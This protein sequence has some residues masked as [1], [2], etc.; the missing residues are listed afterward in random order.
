VLSCGGLIQKRLSAGGEVRVVLLF[1]RIYT[2]GE[3][4]QFVTE[5]DNHFSAACKILGISNSINYYFNE[6]LKYG[7]YYSFLKVIEQELGS[8]N[9][10]EV[11][12]HSEEDLHQSH[13]WLADIS[14]VVL[15]PAN[16]GSVSRILAAFGMDSVTSASSNWFEILT[17]DQVFLK[18]QAMN[19]YERERRGMPH[20]RAHE[21]LVALHQVIGARCGNYWAEP[22]KL[23]FQKN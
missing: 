23:L 18:L 13:R 21:N 3:G 1:R 5:Q 8:F 17:E 10:D 12:V 20:Q 11:V 2:Y 9:P 7:E 4:E 14:K 16:I 22:Y 15:R 19:C 6:E